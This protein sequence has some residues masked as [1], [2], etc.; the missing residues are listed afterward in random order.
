MKIGSWNK[1]PM[2]ARFLA[3]L[4]GIPLVAAL[5]RVGFEHG[6]HGLTAKVLALVSLGVLGLLL[7]LTFTSFPAQAPMS[8]EEKRREWRNVD[9]GIAIFCAVIFAVGAVMFIALAVMPPD[10]LPSV[11]RWL[12]R[13]ASFIIAGVCLFLSLVFILRV[14]LL[15]TG[16]RS[17]SVQLR[18]PDSEK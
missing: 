3:V 15:L 18:K 14:R 6:F 17:L 7:Q 5:L 1:M 8:K 13:V 9:L 16:K 10:D 11:S 2:G 12:I 4:L